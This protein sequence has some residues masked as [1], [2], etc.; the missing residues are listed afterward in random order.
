LV[1]IG[2]I[3]RGQL[4]VEVEGQRHTIGPREFGCFPAGVYHVVVEVYPPVETLMIRA[5]SVPDKV[6]WTR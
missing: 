2:S 6:Y 5:P 1:Q 4:V 3:L